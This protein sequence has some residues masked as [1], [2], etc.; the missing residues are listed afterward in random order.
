MR[1]QFFYTV[2][3]EDPKAAPVTGSFNLNKIVRTMEYEPGKMM[4]LMDDLHTEVR[5]M[6][7]P[8]KNGKITMVSQTM[9][10]ASEIY[11]NEADSARYRALVE[12]VVQA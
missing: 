1:N 8:G 5:K 9:S 10:V 6:P 3:Q 12:L 4:C 7:Q 2:I 11:L